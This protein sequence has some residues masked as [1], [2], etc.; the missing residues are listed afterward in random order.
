[1]TTSAVSERL[2]VFVSYAR[3][4][5]SNLA[6]ELVV[7]L[8][9][10]GFEAYLDRED[11]SAGEDW[12]ERLGVLIRQADT[13]VF[14]I[15][16]RSV[17]S[18]R[19]AWEVDLAKDLAKR[20][21]PAVGLPVEEADV[22][23]ALRRLNFIQ[24]TPGASFARGLA[25]LVD[26]LRV[27]LDW[28]REHTRLGELARRWTDRGEVQALLLRDEE[29]AAAQNWVAGWRAELPAVT[30]AHRIFL[31]ASVEAQDLRTNQERQRIEAMARANAERADALARQEQAMR[32]LKR[33]TVIA[34]L[35]VGA[36][37]LGLAGTAVW[38]TQQRERALEAHIRRESQRRDVAGQ[39]V[40][41][42]T[43]PGQMAMDTPS[44]SPYST[45]LLEALASPNASLWGALSATSMRVNRDSKGE[46]RPF[47]S[48]DMNADLYLSQPPS[49]RRQ[50]AVV[51]AV[52]RYANMSFDIPGVYRD[53]SAWTPFLRTRR[54]AVTELR[55]PKL[56]EIKSVLDA[57]RVADLGRSDPQLHKVGITIDE[58]DSVAKPV[59]PP[60]TL[61]LVVYSGIGVLHGT[62]RFL[63]ATDLAFEESKEGA[64]PPTPL[65]ALSAV[66]LESRMRELAA[67]SV[68]VY[69]TMFM[70][71][72]ST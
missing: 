15:T 27:D 64:Q 61:L 68:A 34:G 25:Q 42:A 6:E 71:Q 59:P 17:G 65:G 49:T 9:V 26:A 29:L 36:L 63:A 12:E 72:R 50:H 23:P 3:A 66:R 55:D 41:Y 39:I 31:A 45:A 46:Q 62:E 30:E 2:R 22:P 57:L 5:G 20:I 60:D 47:V 32:L 58:G 48:S 35:G 40:A 33:R 70:E 14:L 54:F 56:V 18:K 44:G 53:F 37:S 4:D 28:I 24:F 19:C 7:A 52:G 13:V 1:M 67:A 10:A 8:E 51:I 38:A 16:P 11:I 43:S 21:I 69:D